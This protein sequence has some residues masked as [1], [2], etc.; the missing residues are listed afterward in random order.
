MT[1]NMLFVADKQQLNTAAR[2]MLS[3]GQLQH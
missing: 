3:A 2:R 1:L